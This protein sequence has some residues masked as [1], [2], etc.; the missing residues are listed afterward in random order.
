MAIGKSVFNVV[1]SSCVVLLSG[2]AC[3]DAQHFSG[4]GNT[5]SQACSDAKRNAE[6]E[7]G[8]NPLYVIEQFGRCDC[9]KE[10]SSPE[11]AKIT[12]IKQTYRCGVDVYL[13]KR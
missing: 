1:S 2:V 5:E 10:E 8:G 6:K 4:I 7:I 13:R 11:F 3:A 12:G 9:S